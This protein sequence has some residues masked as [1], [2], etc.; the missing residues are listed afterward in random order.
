MTVEKDLNDEFTFDITCGN[1]VNNITVKLTEGEYDGNSLIAELQ[2]QIN[3]KLEAAGLPKDMV[4]AQIGG[5]NTGVVGAN[6]NDA[7]C[8]KINDNTALPDSGQYIIDGVRGSAA[9]NIFYQ[10]DGRM[11]PAYTTGAKDITDGLTVTAENNTL[12]L[13]ADGRT[14]SV[15]LADGDYTADEL[16]DAV[17][18]GFK[19][20]G[21]P[22]TAK[23]EDGRLKIQYNSFGRHI[24]DNVAG[25]A[26]DSLFYV[27]N[28]AAGEKENIKIQL[29]GNAGRDYI[30]LDRPVM[31]TVSLGI[32]SVA[33]TKPKYANKALGRLAGALDAVSAIRSDY[34]AME[35]RLEHA[36]NGNNNTAENTQ[37]AESLVRDT[38][39]ASETVR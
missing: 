15:T 28:S 35:N 5:V 30:E 8:L 34:G 10:T 26:R 25:S 31:N 37:S 12:S 2:K 27:K 17:N 39:I 9:F 4:K 11:I 29:S 21:A 38:D 36:I 7:L 24:I 32:N 1:T 20:G 3:K 33:I 19:A 18:A 22:L 23:I 14:Y 13:D 16:A 6:D